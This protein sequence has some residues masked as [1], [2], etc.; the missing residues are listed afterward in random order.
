MALLVAQILRKRLNKENEDVT[1]KLQKRGKLANRRVSFAPDDELETKHIFKEDFPIARDLCTAQVAAA[2]HTHIDDQI[3]SDHLAALENLSPQS[4]ELTNN[5]LEQPCAATVQVPGPGPVESTGIAVTGIE[6]PSEYQTHGHYQQRA[7]YARNLDITLNVPNLSTLVEE[8]EEDFGAGDISR[9]LGS[10]ADTPSMHPVMLDDIGGG[11]LASESPTSPNMQ[12]CSDSKHED[13]E[14]APLRDFWGFAP[15]RDDTLDV[16]YRKMVMGEKTYNAVYG[17]VGIVPDAGG[18]RSPLRGGPEFVP[19]AEG[20]GAAAGRTVVACDAGPAAPMQVQPAKADLAPP[21]VPAATQAVQPP[22]RRAPLQQQQPQQTELSAIKAEPLQSFSLPQALAAQQPQTRVQ[23]HSTPFM[24][25]TMRLL[26]D[27]TEAWRLPGHPCAYDR[28]RLSVASNRVLAPGTRR[29]AGGAGGGETTMLLGPTMTMASAGNGNTVQLLADTT[30]QR[31][32][33]ERLV[34]K[35]PGRQDP[36]AVEPLPRPA[37]GARPGDYIAA[38]SAAAE[39]RLAAFKAQASLD[40]KTAASS[41][42][43]E[44][45]GL[46]MDAHFQMPP[47]PTTEL[48]QLQD[49]VQARQRPVHLGS[50]EMPLSTTVALS[51]G[52]GMSVS[53]QAARAPPCAARAPSRLSCEEFLG[54]IDVSFI[55]KVYRDTFQPGSDPPPK[56]VAEVYAAATCTRA[57]VDAYHAQSLDLAARLANTGTRVAHLE[58]ELTANKQGLFMAVQMLP[59]AQ[60]KMVKMQFEGLK[61]LCRLRTVKQVKQ[62]QLGVMEDHLAQLGARKLQLQADLDAFTAEFERLRVCAEEVESIPVVITRMRQDDEERVQEVLQRKR[63]IESHLQRLKALRAQ[64][65]ERQQRLGAMQAEQQAKEKGRPSITALMEERCQL[66]E[67]AAELRSRLDNSAMTPG[68]EE[69]LIREAVRKSETV[70]ALLGLHSLRLD[71]TNM[72]HTGTFKLL[73]RRAYSIVCT[74]SDGFMDIRVTCQDATAAGLDGLAPSIRDRVHA[75]STALSCTIPR[76]QLPL[77]LEYTLEQLQR[78]CRVAQQLESCW[79][80]F[81]CLQRPYAEPAVALTSQQGDAGDNFALVLRFTNADTITGVTIR[82]PWSAALRSDYVKPRL[83]V[84]LMS[85]D[86]PVTQRQYCDALLDTVLNKLPPGT[87]YI[88]AICYAM[89]ETLQVPSN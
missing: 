63:T 3:G 66:E 82:M 30:N 7:V 85:L 53:A 35:I 39:Q 24:D 49:E 60:L 28:G 16:D 23:V 71:I 11:Y 52:C 9:R 13:Q 87:G 5:G 44:D 77:R 42:L 89:S 59:P 40:L 79:L 62:A 14:D 26:D 4:M 74:A 75:S 54:L 27:Q 17:T 55:N 88:T 15:G 32:A 56:T 58:A 19:T 50:G 20:R 48:S 46:T 69:Q 80:R 78:M 84:Q 47:E 29:G 43:L 45:G 68:S 51:Q 61:E 34:Q 33:Y 12:M 70:E 25:N 2:P 18:V 73:F 6:P 38:S 31:G 64:N 83:S 8:D 76:V 57:Y 65:A 22:L 81:D 37:V 36:P 86:P 67:R 21:A 41:D 72:E 10:C 1:A